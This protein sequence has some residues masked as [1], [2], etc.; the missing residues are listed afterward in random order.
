VRSAESKLREW[1]R[2]HRQALLATPVPLHVIDDPRKFGYFI[3]HAHY[4]ED[5]EG[6]AVDAASFSLAQATALLALLC[7]ID[8]LGYG[9]DLVTVLKRAQ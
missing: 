4:P 5:S 8:D 3:E 6:P 7:D 9:N 2:R 1:L